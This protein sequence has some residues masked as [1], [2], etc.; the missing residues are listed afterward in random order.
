MILCQ[1]SKLIIHF[2]VRRN[3]YNARLDHTRKYLYINVFHF[4]AWHKSIRMNF[5]PN[6]FV[7]IVVVLNVLQIKTLIFLE[8]NSYNINFWKNERFKDYSIIFYI[9]FILF[10][11]H[12]IRKI[13]LM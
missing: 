9:K 11:E 1:A 2:E 3:G 10:C 7:I 8:K 4:D 5:C 6:I 12:F 13:E